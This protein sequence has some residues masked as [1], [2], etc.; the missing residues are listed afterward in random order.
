MTLEKRVNE[1]PFWSNLKVTLLGLKN[2]IF[3]N[4]PELGIFHFKESL[5]GQ[6]HFKLWFAH[7]EEFLISMYLS[8]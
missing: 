1:I 5:V 2:L 3:G 7:L 4:F 8:S 6:S